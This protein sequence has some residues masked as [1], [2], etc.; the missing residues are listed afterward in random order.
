MIYKIWD[1]NNKR[2]I[3]EDFSLTATKLE[4][5]C[6]I[7]LS[8]FSRNMCKSSLIMNPFWFEYLTIFNILGTPPHI[9]PSQSLGRFDF[10]SYPSLG[11]KKGIWNPWG[12]QLP[13]CDHLKNELCLPQFLPAGAWIS[14]QKFTNTLLMLIT[15]VQI[16]EQKGTVL[17]K[18]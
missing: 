13:I 14:H 1:V 17:K 2:Y 18:F 7:V 11:E 8:F 16:R 6:R 10:L 9:A 4:I 3:F 5:L 12:S 15:V